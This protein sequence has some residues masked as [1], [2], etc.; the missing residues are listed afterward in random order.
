MDCR[1]LSGSWTSTHCRERRH[2]RWRR[3]DDTNCSQLSSANFPWANF[4]LAYISPAYVRARG[5]SSHTHTGRSCRE[6][7]H[8]RALPTFPCVITDLR[9]NP[10]A[11]TFLRGR[12]APSRYRNRPLPLFLP[13]EDSFW[14]G[15]WASVSMLVSPS[16]HFVLQTKLYET[17]ADNRSKTWQWLFASVLGLLLTKEMHVSCISPAGVMGDHQQVGELRLKELHWVRWLIPSFAAHL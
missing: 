10:A 6:R 11:G 12:S 16:P 17:R 3:P 9:F 4:A 7:S 13:K 8:R 15:G 14:H 5:W 1:T 2:D